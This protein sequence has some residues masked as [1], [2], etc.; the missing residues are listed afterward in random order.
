MDECELIA[1]ISTVACALAK[2]CSTDD[3]T[4]M[5]V[6]FTQLGDS[7]A[8]ILAKRGLSSNNNNGNSNLVPIP[9]IDND[10]S[11]KIDEKD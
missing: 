11:A 6:V 5:S 4:I 3:L 10:D 8:T 9:D 2:S 7:L 1:F